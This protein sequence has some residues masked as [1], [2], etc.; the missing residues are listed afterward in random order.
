SGGRTRSRLRSA[1]RGAAASSSSF[2]RL[3]PRHFLG[4][5]RPGILARSRLTGAIYVRT[6]GPAA[7][8]FGS[9][10]SLDAPFLNPQGHQRAC[11]G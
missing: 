8:H 5:K 10:R 1:A 4:I 11:T 2:V 7:R 6:A 3:G 9:A